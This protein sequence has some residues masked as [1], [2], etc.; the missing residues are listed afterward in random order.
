MN[1]ED[2]VA[3]AMSELLPALGFELEDSYEERDGEHA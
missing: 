3:K 1:E 2:F